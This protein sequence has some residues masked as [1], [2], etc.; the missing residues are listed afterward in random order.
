MLTNTIH[1]SLERS[2]ALDP[3]KSF[4]VQA[5]AGSGKTELL[6]QRFLALLNCVKQPEEILAIT[7]T[8]KSAAEMR[9]RIINALKRAATEP[10]PTAE[11][12]KKT[13]QMAKHVLQRNQSLQWNLLDN[14]NRLRIQTIDS[15]NAHITKQLPILSH[16]GA[17]PDITDDPVALY[18]EA[19]QEFLSHL[20]ENVTWSDAIAQLLSHLDNDLNK[21]ETLLI[22]MLAKR[23]QWLPHITLNANDPELRIKL[24]DHLAAVL[25]DI[26]TN[27]TNTF[28]RELT[29]ELLT[30]A[31]FA[32]SNLQRENSPSR[33]T[34]CLDLTELPGAHSLDI[35]T[36]LGLSDLLLNKEFDW[37]KQYDK[38]LG[39]SAPASASN[40]QEKQSFT[41]LKQR[42][43]TLVGQFAEHEAFRLALIELNLAPAIY[44]EDSQWQTLAALQQALCVVVA[45]LHL[46]FQKHRQIDYIESAQAALAALGTDDAPTDMTLAL[47]YQLQHILI[48]EFQDTSHSQF[49]LIEK[50]TAGWDS[51]DGRTLF[52]VGD[53]M[54]SIY[55]FREAEVG[56]FIRVRKNGLGQI[57]LHPL[58]LAVNFRST[59]GIVNWV[60]QHFQQVLPSFEDIA[61]GAV[62][63]NASIANQCQNMGSEKAVHLHS[64]IDAP[65]SAQ[66][67]AIV[68][69]I[70]QIKHEKPG[71]TIAILVR[72]RSHLQTIIPALKNAQLPYRAIDIDPLSSRPVIQD[73]LALTRSL[74]HPADRIAWLGI[75]RA[76]WCG[77]NLSDL[78]LLS[79]NDAK[80][81]LYEQLAT[82]SIVEQLSQKGQLRLKRILPILQ[83]KSADRYRYPLRTWIESTW[84][85]LGGP[86][87]VNKQSDLDDAAAFF[88][89]LDTMN[90]TGDPLH[91]ETLT[92]KV[93]QLFAAPNNQADNSLQIMTVHNAKGL[94]FDTVILPHLERRSPSDDK[95]LLLWMERPLQDS[96]HALLLAPVHA[97]GNETDPIY[98]YVKRQHATKTDYESG[99]LLYVAATRA[100]KQLH[101]FFSL[102]KNDK[103]EITNPVSSSLLGKLWPAIV[104]SSFIQHHTTTTD[105]PLIES[106]KLISRLSLTWQNPII[107]Q[108]QPISFHNKTSGF[109]LSDTTPKLT[110]ILIHSILQNISQYGVDWWQSKSVEKINDYIKTSLTR[111]G[112]TP[113][114]LEEAIHT[115][116]LAISNTLHDPRGQWIL[117]SHHSAQ[118]EWQ[119]TALIDNTVQS[120][121]IDRTFID[122]D[123][124]RWII[125]YKTAQP[126]NES[127]DS[128]LMTEEKKYSLKMLN[129]AAAIGRIGPNPIKLGLYFPLIPTWREW[130][131]ETL[132]IIEDK[133]S[134][135][136]D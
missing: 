4:I 76:P 75:L 129:Y 111:L 5:P 9:A 77:L 89:L 1:D 29:T 78:L 119:L 122:A 68:E 66:A 47:D 28:P 59:E 131:N 17:T 95:Q 44:Y 20:E 91:I 115:V 16:F 71:E 82:P 31:D 38:R 101:L 69:L 108:I 93:N 7:F 70:K 24:E 134:C 48:D 86:A 136:T 105:T 124:I 22:N 126:G 87:C 127:I 11:H 61:T 79:G 83:I 52:V 21:I 97:I 2:Q 36:W 27:I 34:H 121:I 125:D 74:L 33:I 133:H 72:S 104:K 43:T 99:R 18:R 112:I 116:T 46:I 132:H 110:G 55:R 106:Q 128:F 30:L 62:S 113:A 103:D 19:V 37:R 118:S 117:Q 12:A 98:E 13:W 3:Q 23:D 42:M 53:P 54:Q 130:N 51:H 81:S 102:Q 58:T 56:L 80:I 8:K 14:P 45:Q 63:Y 49:K 85:L 26:L 64:L 135:S 25:T 123:G 90:Q 65:E 67:N 88:N 6:T 35:D 107:E 84:L 94:E 10:E 41:H 32:A 15:F 60:N 73:L 109:Q 39:F 40:P 114:R 100:K 96:T 50:L 57:K 92:N 120:L